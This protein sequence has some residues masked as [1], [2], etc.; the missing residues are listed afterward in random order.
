M[1]TNNI[2]KY[3]Q[4]NDF[5]L[6]EYEFNRDDVN[7]PLGTDGI[8]TYLAETNSGF[9]QFFTSPN[10]N[11]TNNSLL[12]QSSPINDRRSRWFIDIDDTSTYY[13]NVFESVENIGQDEYPHDIVKIHI[14]SGYNFDDIPGFLLQIRAEDA[15][16]G[17]VDISNFTW[18]KQV[19]GS[20]VV[21]FSAQPIFLGNK[22]YDKYLEFKIPSIGKL[23][24]V[25]SEPIEDALNVKALSDIHVQYSTITSIDEY[26]PGNQYNISEKVQLQLPVQSNADNFNCFIAEST[27]GDYIEYYATWKGI[28]IGEY[29]GDIESG[30]IPLFT[31]NNPN[32][33]F[34]QFTT[35][36]GFEAAKWVVMHEIQVFEHIPPDTQLLTQR[37]YFIQENNFLTPN[38]F[39]PIVVNADIA[40]EYTINYICRLTNRMDGSQIIRQATFSSLDPKKYGRTFERLNVDNIIPLRVFN[41]LPDEKPNVITGVG[42]PKIKFSKVFF[43]TT[44]VVLNKEN[45]VLPQG[46]GPLFL[47]KGDSVYKFKFERLNTDTETPETENIDLSGVYNYALLFVLDDDSHIEVIPTYS[48]NM[49][50]SLGELE[51]KLTRDQVVQL[52]KQNNNTYSIIVKN[53]DGTE[54]TFY[55]G[56]YYSKESTPEVA[57]EY[58]QVFQA[59]NLTSEISKLEAKVNKL[60]R[61]NNTLRLERREDIRVRRAEE[62]D[63]DD[64]VAR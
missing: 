44:N 18:V 61:E 38:R 12:L 32:D 43:D 31:S 57:E 41:R 9:K 20:Q 17:Y 27:E 50:T 42:A 5:I 1:A 48:S 3:V 56:L 13:S 16:E 55:Q 40:S 33:N 34:D 28:I 49:N 58:N 45:E 53:P 11:D 29:M 35:Q 26:S 19:L 2:S 51:F 52:L 22:F 60:E 24:G 15:S 47:T 39:R 4:I 59:A 36:Y 23:G 21:K 37:F 63:D 46:T 8:G 7:T 10:I 64:T 14:I 6:L 25:T 62:R 30:R 54:Y